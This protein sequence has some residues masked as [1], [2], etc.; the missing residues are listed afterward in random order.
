MPAQPQGGGDDRECDQWARACGAPSDD[1]ASGEHARGDEAKADPEVRDRVA[2]RRRGESPQSKEHG[3]GEDDRA[4]RGQDRIGPGRSADHDARGRDA[5]RHTRQDVDLRQYEPQRRT[6]LR[7]AELSAGLHI[8]RQ[9]GYQHE[10]SVRGET[11][12]VPEDPATSTRADGHGDAQR[13]A[14][15]QEA[16]GDP[17]GRL[18]EAGRPRRCRDS[19]SRGGDQPRH[20]ERGDGRPTAIFARYHEPTGDRAERARRERE[21]LREAF[22]Q[23]RHL[24]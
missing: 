20:A 5:Q 7:A 3:L 18:A 24:L 22:A 14:R 1:G 10:D 12:G 4:A 9:L 13:R 17:K 15:D 19:V 21:L 23:H 16:S 8:E 6:V 2:R 11:D